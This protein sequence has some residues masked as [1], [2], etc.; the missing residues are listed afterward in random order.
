MARRTKGGASASP[1]SH[2]Q[3]TIMSDT[4]VPDAAPDETAAEIAAEDA[5]NPDLVPMERGGEV[6]NIH[7]LRVAEHIGLGWREV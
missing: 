1:V 6:L 7:R 2:L 3:E 5:P 4:Q